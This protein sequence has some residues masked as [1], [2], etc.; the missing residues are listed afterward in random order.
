MDIHLREWMELL[1]FLEARNN[2]LAKAFAKYRE[3]EKAKWPEL[4]IDEELRKEENRKTKKASQ[5]GQ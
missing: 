2:E 5:G 4:G 1:K 3:T